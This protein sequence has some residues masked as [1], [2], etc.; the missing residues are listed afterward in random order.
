MMRSARI[1]RPI[2]QMDGK[3][4][5]ASHIPEP[6][7]NWLDNEILHRRE[8][9]VNGRKILDR[10]Q[11]PRGMQVSTSDLMQDCDAESRKNFA[12]KAISN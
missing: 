7:R 12:N 4:Q 5:I 6:L 9:I 11:T 1:H 10:R 2:K 3:A 8:V